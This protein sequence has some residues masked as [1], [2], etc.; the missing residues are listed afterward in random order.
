M[1]LQSDWQP[2]GASPSCLEAVLLA[3]SALPL[4]LEATFVCHHKTCNNQPYEEPLPEN[5]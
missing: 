5:D 2:E 1:L 4:Q 3:I